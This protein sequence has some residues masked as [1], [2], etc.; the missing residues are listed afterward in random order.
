VVDD[1]ARHIQSKIYAMSI[2]CNTIASTFK[3]EL[4][5]KTDKE[6]LEEN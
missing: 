6:A 2:P 5:L 1:R 3:E 4:G